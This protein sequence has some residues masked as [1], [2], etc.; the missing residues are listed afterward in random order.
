MKDDTAFTSMRRD[1][2]IQS[3]EYGIHHIQVDTPAI[4]DIE[5]AMV[6][7]G[8][9]RP[10]GALNYTSPEVLGLLSQYVAI[11]LMLGA[12]SNLVYPVFTVY[13][14][15]SGAQIHGITALTVIGWNLKVLFGILSDCFPIFGYRRK[16]WMVIGWLACCAVL[17]CLAT[18]DAGGP[19]IADTAYF[20]KAL[21]TDP[22]LRAS[23]VN[24][25]AKTRGSIVGM[26]CGVAVISYV[27]AD[28]AA[29]ALFVEMAQREPE[30]IRGRLQSMIYVARYVAT[31]IA[32]AV[33]GLCLNS[34][35]YGGTFS[36]SM[37]QQW[38]FVFLAV[39]C[40]IMVPISVTCV[41]DAPHRGVHFGQYMR[42]F[43]QLVQNRAMWQFMVFRFSFN[44]LSSGLVTTA[45]PYVQYHWAHVTTMNSQLFSIAGN[46]VFAGGLAYT[47]SCGTAWNW[48]TVIV[49]T[50]LSIVAVDAA[51]TFC[52]IYDVV[53]NEYVYLVVTQVI[54]N[55]PSAVQ[56]LVTGF[57]IVELAEMGNEGITYALLSTMNNLPI[58]FGPLVGNIVSGQFNVTEADVVADT[59]RDRHNVAYTYLIYYM[60][61]IL[62]CGV[63]VLCPSQKPQVY[64]LKVQ[65][66]N[67][68]VVAAVVLV[69][70]FICLMF[71]I[72]VSLLSMFPSTQCLVVAGGKGCHV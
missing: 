64:Q 22:T 17:V 69:L 31:V 15:M 12:F 19:Y 68:P 8:A 1:D 29:D 71:S 28:V 67:Q 26:L 48:R 53:R 42:E 10:G 24:E 51:V 66:G 58:A 36:W 9:L 14:R 13:F 45:A 70:S 57:I 49:A 44:F 3:D 50:N 5:A 35:E 18:Y 59:R 25:N 43:W 23:L 46:L 20:R 16:S 6:Y 7:A 4:A 39:P 63:V 72:V 34:E 33:I 52:T 61:A 55:I 47:G 32:Q 21:P 40:A 38:F 27:V 41:D 11:G 62:A 56:F 30:R 60:A 2:T 37:G 65:G 54:E